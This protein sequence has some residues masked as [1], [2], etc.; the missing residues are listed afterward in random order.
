[1]S[2]TK[3]EKNRLHKLAGIEPP[4]RKQK[5]KQRWKD[6]RAA[7]NMIKLIVLIA[8]VRLRILPSPK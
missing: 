1:M 5:A 7:W 3:E 2:L 6:V 8:L 4:T